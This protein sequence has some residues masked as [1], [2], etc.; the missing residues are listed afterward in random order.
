MRERRHELAALA[1]ASAPSRGPRPTATSPRR[2]TSSSTTRAARRARAWR[3]ARPGPGRAQLDA[4]RGARRLRG[5]RPVELP[6]RDPH[7]HDSGRP[8]DGQHRDPQARR[9]GP[10]LRRD[11]RR[12]AAR[13]RRAPPAPSAL[14]P[15]E[16]EAGAALVED[17]RVHTIAF[18]GSMPVGLAILETAAQ[19]PRRPEATSSA[20]SP[21]WAARTA[22]S[23]TP[24]PTSTTPCPR[25]CAPRSSTP[26]RSARPPR[27]VLVHEAIAER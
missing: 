3:H 18:T 9:A 2:S 11:G 25:S 23:S 19:G 22:S 16:G 12:G 24:T 10:R 1:C 26:A 21:R 14:L 6:D 5:H 7:G 15:G 8:G 27:R 17:P 13:R 20:S 4:L